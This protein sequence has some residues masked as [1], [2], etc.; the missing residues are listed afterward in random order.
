M[1][2]WSYLAFYAIESRRPFL[3]LYPLRAHSYHLWF[4]STKCFLFQNINALT[5]P[6][7]RLLAQSCVS[8]FIRRQILFRQ[9][10]HDCAMLL[11]LANQS[12]SSSCR[13]RPW[14]QVQA[15]GWPGRA[16][17]LHFTRPCSYR[18]S[19]DSAGTWHLRSKMLSGHFLGC[20]RIACR[21]IGANPD[22][23]LISDGLY[24]M[25]FPPP[26]VQWHLEHM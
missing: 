11:F 9:P 19:K 1:T 7:V 24:V 4:S 18:T 15:C 14:V 21:R 20:T 8:M 10:G 13:K 3:T 5:Y 17:K 23:R 2:E 26:Y 16:L 12:L 6:Q 22:E 25:N